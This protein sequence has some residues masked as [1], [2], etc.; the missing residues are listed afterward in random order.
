MSLFVFVCVCVR[1]CVSVHTKSVQAH[2]KALV[3]NPN[4]SGRLKHNINLS[5]EPVSNKQPQGQTSKEIKQRVTASN[6]FS[7]QCVP[8]HGIHNHRLSH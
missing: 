6:L 2:P 3:I 7:A 5:S 4:I 8:P 1:A